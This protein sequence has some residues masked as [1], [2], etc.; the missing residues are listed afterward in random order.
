[1]TS[2]SETS[3]RRT[4]WKVWLLGSLSTVGLFWERNNSGLFLKPVLLYRLHQNHLES[5][6]KMQVPI[7]HPGPT[8]SGSLRVQLQNLHYLKQAS[9]AILLTS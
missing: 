8:K 9:Q 5:L 7:S 3:L 4:L 1:M 6:L 2:S